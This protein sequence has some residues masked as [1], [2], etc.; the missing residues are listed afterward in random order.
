MPTYLRTS[1][2]S[3]RLGRARKDMAGRRAPF[4]TLE[5]PSPRERE[6]A[7]GGTS[8]LPKCSQQPPSPILLLFCW[9]D[10]HARSPLP[11]PPPPPPPP[12]RSGRSRR[13]RL[14]SFSQAEA[15]ERRGEEE[16][17]GLLFVRQLCCRCPLFFWGGAVKGRRMET[18]R[19]GGAEGDDDRTPKKEKTL[20]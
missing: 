9:R 7:R 12:P 15:S 18:W 17:K 5:A 20:F 8:S 6:K 10:L 1:S 3:P 4:Y 11:A 16:R 2:S 19:N 13:C 14:L